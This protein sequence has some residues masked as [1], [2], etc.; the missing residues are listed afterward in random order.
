MICLLLCCRNADLCFNLQ[1]CRILLGITLENELC[2][3]SDLKRIKNTMVQLE[4]WLPSQF[5]SQESE[6]IR[7]TK[8]EQTGDNAIALLLEFRSIFPNLQISLLCYLFIFLLVSLLPTPFLI[9]LHR[10]TIVTRHMRTHS[11]YCVYAPRHWKFR[12][13]LLSL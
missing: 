8:G 3:S 1:L 5:L 4:K 9:N 11:I 12:Y 10:H 2:S 7:A 13:S 6:S